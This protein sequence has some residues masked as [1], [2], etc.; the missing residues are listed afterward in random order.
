MSRI[1]W[2]VVALFAC[3]FM[4]SGCAEPTPARGSAI[5]HAADANARASTNAKAADKA[6]VEA[7]EAKGRADQ[8]TAEAKAANTEAAIA[9][10]TDARVEAASKLAVAD[11]LDRTAK[12]AAE[13]ARKAEEGARLEREA[14][15]RAEDDRAW[16]RLCRLIGL[17]GVAAGVLIGGLLCYLTKGITPGA[18]IGG[19]IALTGILV[20]AFGAT[21]S[22]LPIVLG[23]TVVGGLIAWAIVHR[24][25]LHA[26]AAAWNALP[27]TADLGQLIEKRL[28]RI[29]GNP[30]EPAKAT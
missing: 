11:A 23:V 25:D 22:W 17:I 1:T 16:T 26:G 21:V 12:D 20:V 4:L 6:R 3:L 19:T 14:D 30:Y 9:K 24:K 15:A 29:S 7:A 28:G 13:E 5:E 18:P 10:A 27:D 2:P 8:L